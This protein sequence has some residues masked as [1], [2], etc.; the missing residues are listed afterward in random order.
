MHSSKV[1]N[2][3]SVTQTHTQILYIQRYTKVHMV[4]HRYNTEKVQ[5]RHSFTNIHTDTY[6]DGHA[7]FPPSP[8]HLNFCWVGFLFIFVFWRGREYSKEYSKWSVSGKWEFHGA[9]SKLKELGGSNEAAH[10]PH[11]THNHPATFQILIE[12]VSW[13][14]GHSHGRSVFCST[15]TELILSDSPL[16]VFLLL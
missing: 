5:N 14:K 6:P 2:I 7:S 11:H 15:Q 12:N 8:N 4:T 3:D 1:T 16:P 9:V 13:L 10:T